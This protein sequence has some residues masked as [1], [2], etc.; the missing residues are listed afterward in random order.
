[1]PQPCAEADC[2]TMREGSWISDTPYP[3]KVTRIGGPVTPPPLVRAEISARAEGKTRGPGPMPGPKPVWIRRIPSSE[4]LPPTVRFEDD[5]DPAINARPEA[6]ESANT[7]R[8]RREQ[9]ESERRGL[10]RA[11]ERNRHMMRNKDTIDQIMPDSVTNI[12]LCP[13][14]KKLKQLKEDL[15]WSTEEWTH[16]FHGDY[17]RARKEAEL[18]A[19]EHVCKDR[20]TGLC[21]KVEGWFRKNL[22]EPL[23]TEQELDQALKENARRRERVTQEEEQWQ[24]PPP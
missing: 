6:V 21:G 12:P 20:G 5:E 4:D 7:I 9:A 10:L 2:S 17:D 11:K 15:E 8:A 14:C 23:P 3:Y 16:L 18:K 13:P 24:P 22:V 19:F 1:M